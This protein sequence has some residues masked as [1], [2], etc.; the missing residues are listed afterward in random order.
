MPRI[1]RTGFV[2]LVMAVLGAACGSGGDAALTR[3]V[4][5]PAVTKPP[6]TAPG[7]PSA[8]PVGP[9]AAA[10]EILSREEV[11]ATVGNP[12]RPGTGAG[13]FCSW[14]TD[15]DA[16]TSANLTVTRPAPAKAAEECTTERNALPKEAKQE[17][18]SG[19]GSSAVWYWQQVSIL[20]QGSFLACWGDAVVL[21]M[22]TGEHDQGALR[23]TA[24]NFAQKVH[25]RL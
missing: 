21:V 25:S 1:A 10:C 3:G 11:G 18:V 17:Q 22:L 14:G 6:P 7:T 15:V 12:V 4:P 19:V 5:G 24:A 16:G 13:K 8:P 20:L 2:L 9:G 23:T